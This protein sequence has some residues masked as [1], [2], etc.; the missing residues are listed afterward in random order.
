MRHLALALTGMLL[1]A[2]ALAE[3]IIFDYTGVVRSIREV[4]FSGMDHTVFTSAVV[5][6]TITLG[7]TFHGRL[8]YNTELRSYLTPNPSAYAAYD[9]RTGSMVGRSTLV[10]DK[11]GTTMSS[12]NIAPDFGIANG[13]IDRI[14]IGTSGLFNPYLGVLAFEFVDPTGSAL[15]S[16]AIP[17][18]IDYTAFEWAGP[19]LYWET[20]D[21]RL[22]MHAEGALTSFVRINP[23]P[24]PAAYAMLA[25]GLAIVIGGA[26]RRRSRTA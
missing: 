2:P 3:M 25:A 10:L 8:Y 1:S 22:G 26:A 17:S 24:E 16:T 19:Q 14:Y 20:P 18:A 23:V 21:G 7:D 4:N 11:S 6:G 12:D 15:S 9:G 5:P 13:T